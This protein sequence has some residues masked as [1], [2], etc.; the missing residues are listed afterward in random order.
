MAVDDKTLA[1][2]SHDASI[3]KIQPQVVVFPKDVDDI[4]N[5]VKFVAEAK[6]RGE[7][8]SLT[9]RAAG[10]DMTGGPLS[11]SIVVSTTR[12]LNRLKKIG[13]DFAVVEPGMFY[14]DFE[15]ETLKSNL[16]LPSFPASRELCTVGGMAA[17]N[18]GGELNL[19]YGKT[20][21]YIR[22]LKMVLRDGNEY[23]FK[24][25]NMQELVAKMATPGQKGR[26]TKSCLT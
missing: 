17:N 9:A 8:L 13:K 12:Y 23:L 21:N 10:T 16:L 19:L 18:S 2:F 15:K 25:L 24:P 6:T 26:F 1:D 20:E 4:K 22:E 14:R 7:N 3:Y 11:E 5:L